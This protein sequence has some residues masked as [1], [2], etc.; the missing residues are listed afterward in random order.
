MLSFI[1]N[2]P[3]LVV[4]MRIV[5][6]S[7]GGNAP[8]LFESIGHDTPLPFAS[9]RHGDALRRLLV[10]QRL[11]VAFQPIWDLHSGGI[12]A[13]EALTRP[14]ADYGLTGPL[15]AFDIAEQLGCVHDLDAVC[16]QAVLSRASNLPANV[17]LF[18]N[19]SPHTLGHD[20]FR[21]AALL[22][23]VRAAGLTPER[24]ALEITEQCPARP[25][26]VIRVARELR[27]MGFLLALDDVGAGNAGLEMLRRLPVD[28]VKID[29]AVIAHALRDDAARM[30]FMAIVAVAEKAQCHI[31]AE[32]IETTALFDLAQQA[33]VRGVQGY[34][35]G[36]PGELGTAVPA[37]PQAL[38]A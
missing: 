32:G 7:C 28:F 6:T 8:V 21:A 18:L 36:R 27:R 10:G 1:T 17:L 16:Q 13:F 4:L 29:R 34:L 30:V 20:D 19:I 31:I 22:D 12:L 35:L 3:L 23:V 38:T 5:H 37:V 11:S 24:V 2:I 9:P 33:G 15:E 14:A 25:E 26:A